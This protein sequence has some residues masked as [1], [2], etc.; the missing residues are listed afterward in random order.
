MVRVRWTGISTGRHDTNPALSAPWMSSIVV[1][2]WKSMT[3]I[4]LEHVPPGCKGGYCAFAIAAPGEA[5]VGSNPGRAASPR[6]G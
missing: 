1:W 2:A 3:A 4:T 6:G 5:R